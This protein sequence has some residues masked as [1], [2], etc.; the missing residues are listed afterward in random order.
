MKT[1]EVLIRMAFLVLQKK[2][3]YPPIF[4]KM[5][6]QIQIFATNLEILHP[7]KQEKAFQNLNHISFVT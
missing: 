3:R 2:T 4:R 6:A 7:T 1:L 5:T